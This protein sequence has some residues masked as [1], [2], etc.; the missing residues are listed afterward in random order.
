MPGTSV[1]EI[2]TKPLWDS[3]KTPCNIA[4]VGYIVCVNH[5]SQTH[6]SL[7]ARLSAGTD[8]TAWQD[9]QTR[10]G[11][12]IRAVCVRQGLQAADVDDVFQDVLVSLSRAME[13]FRYDPERGRFRAYLRTVVTNAISR[14]WR[15][16]QSAARLSRVEEPAAVAGSVWDDEWRQHHFRSAM[17]TIEQEFSQSDLAAFRMYALE[18]R[19]P[20]AVAG[21][22]GISRDSV[23][24]AKSRVLR[25]L[26]ACI[27]AQVREE[28]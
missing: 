20:E 28:G 18:G 27:E 15:Q 12:L 19:A 9:F 26:G 5:E 8:L 11:D 4:P 13:Q 24:Q 25:R 1:L 17:R 21:E 14:R 2:R 6:V 16:T 10:Y 23:Y 3:A 22:L 7:L